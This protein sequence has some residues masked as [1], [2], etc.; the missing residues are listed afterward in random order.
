M[1]RKESNKLI[2]QFMGYKWD[3]E[4]DNDLLVLDSSMEKVYEVVAYHSHWDWLIPVIDKIT[5]DDLYV[6]Y[7]EYTSSMICDGGIYINTKFISSTYDDVVKFIEWYNEN[8]I[9]VH[10]QDNIDVGQSTII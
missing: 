9:P 10:N 1:E 5:S 6:K 4:N 2:A 3:I 8:I 7:K